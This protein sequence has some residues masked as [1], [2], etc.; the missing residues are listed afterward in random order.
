MTEQIKRDNFLF[1]LILIVILGY[2]PFAFAEIDYTDPITMYDNDNYYNS[3]NLSYTDVGSCQTYTPTENE[4]LTS[5]TYYSMY[6]YSEPTTNFYGVLLSNTGS[7]LATSTEEYGSS[8]L[9]TTGTWGNGTDIEFTFDEE[10][11]QSDTEYCIGARVYEPATPSAYKAFQAETGSTPVIGD[12]TFDV[13]QNNDLLILIEGYGSLP[14]ETETETGGSSIST[15][16][17]EWVIASTT[18]SVYAVGYTVNLYIGILI[19]MLFGFISF[20]FTKI[21]IK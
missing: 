4:Y 6:R 16:T 8:D 7:V 13:T 14:E 17:L 3:Y 11:L 10:E 5:V 12:G 9:T 21:F 19:A 2:P 18:E 20:M 1:T 15:S